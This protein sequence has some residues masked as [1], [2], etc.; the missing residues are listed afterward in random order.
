MQQLR[1]DI[2]GPFPH[3]DVHWTS[4][5]VGALASERSQGDGFRRRRPQPVAAPIGAEPLPGPGYH[6]RNGG[7]AAISSVAPPF[8]ANGPSGNRR[9]SKRPFVGLWDEKTV[10]G[11]PQAGQQPAHT[12]H[13]RTASH[14][15]VMGS[16]VGMNSW[17][18]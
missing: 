4:P 2:H 11:P 18:T 5:A 14:S 12:S 6:R 3:Q 10:K 1:P 13:S 7:Q 8:A 15:D 9:P 16:R 17:A